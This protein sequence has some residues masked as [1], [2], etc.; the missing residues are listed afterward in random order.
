MLSAPSEPVVLFCPTTNSVKS[1]KVHGRLSDG[2]HYESNNM[3]TN[4]DENNFRIGRK[5]G[6]FEFED[7][8]LGDAKGGMFWLK[9][10]FGGKYLVTFGKGYNVWNSFIT[11]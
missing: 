11:T 5:I 2:L 7:S 8:E 4:S 1:L 10:I 6:H 9:G 3:M